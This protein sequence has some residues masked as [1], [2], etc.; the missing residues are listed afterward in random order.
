MINQL[1]NKSICLS[2]LL[3]AFS[4]AGIVRAQT[5]PSTPSR[6][7]SGIE[8]KK[9]PNMP[10]ISKAELTLTQNLLDGH[11]GSQGVTAINARLMVGLSLVNCVDQKPTAILKEPTY[12]GK[13]KYGAFRIGNGPR[14]ITYF[15][16]DVL[17]GGAIGKVYVDQNQNG[18]LTDDGSPDWAKTWD[19]KGVPHHDKKL[20]LHASWG[21]PVEEKETGDY[22]IDFNSCDGLPGVAF[23]RTTARAGSIKL[24]DK[25]YPVVLGES[26]NDGIFTVPADGDRTRHPLA[27]YI[28]LDGAVPADAPAPKVDPTNKHLFTGFNIAHQVQVDGHWYFFRPSL[29]GAQ[30]LAEET[31]AP[32]E[33]PKASAQGPIGVLSS[34]QAPDFTVEAPDGKPMNLSDFKGKTVVLDLWATWCGPCQESMPGLETLYQKIKNQ[35]VVVLSLCVEDKKEAFT[36]WMAEHAGKDYHFTF[37]FDP[38]GR[39]P[40]AVG[41]K[42]NVLGIPSQFV[43]SPEGAIVGGSSGYE[44]H[45]RALL[46]SLRKAGVKVAP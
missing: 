32:G 22:T 14:S 34:G 21:S 42:Y 5:R 7:P 31:T 28:D 25:L 13:P 26:A 24:G 44:P 33:I 8:T 11:A 17:P 35:N 19:F 2:A 27:F 16:M 30:L 37:A 3:M 12:V 20:I 29:S 38:A 23:T 40:G 39:G 45:Q 10:G 6:V 41:T 9:A 36:K 15:A 1:R 4:M 43:I 18:D 46:E